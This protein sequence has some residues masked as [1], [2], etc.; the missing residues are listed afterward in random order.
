MNKVS[1]LSQSFQQAVE[2]LEDALQQEKNEYMRDSAIQRFEFTFDLAWKTLKAVLEEE[3]VICSSPKS[4]LQAAYRNGLVGYDT[5]WLEML[6]MRNE[7]THTYNQST[8]EIVYA[9]L[10]KYMTVFKELANRLQKGK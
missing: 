10:P 8:A 6:K 5:I 9:E 4:C 7:T 1:E 3:G 2:R